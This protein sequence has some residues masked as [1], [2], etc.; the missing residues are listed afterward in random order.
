M[1]AY[2]NAKKPVFKKYA[3]SSNQI[4]VSKE[5]I[6]D[7]KEET[8]LYIKDRFKQAIRMVNIYEQDAVIFNKNPEKLL[9]AVYFDS[10][11]KNEE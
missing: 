7:L 5:K 11:L 2:Y 4:D 3:T 1:V 9:P 10:P 6:Y 8:R